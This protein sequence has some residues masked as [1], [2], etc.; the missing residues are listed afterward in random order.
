[1]QHHRHTDFGMGPGFPVRDFQI[2]AYHTSRWRRHAYA[3]EELR[4][5]EGVFP[6]RI[7]AGQ[8]E[9][10]GCGNAA[11]PSR[12]SDLERRIQCHQ[13]RSQIRGMDDKARTATK[14]RVLL[15][16]AI[17]REALVASCLETV[18]TIAV[19]PAPGA[20]RDIPGQR[21]HV[22]YLRCPHTGGGLTQH[23]PWS[24]Q[25]GMA[26]KLGQGDESADQGFRGG[27]RHRTGIAYGAQI[28]NDVGLVGP[29]FDLLQQIRPAAG[30]G[31]RPACRCCRTG[32][33]H[34]FGYRTRIDIGQRF[35]PIA[36]SILSR[37][38]GSD[39]MR[40]P[41]ALKMAFATAAGAR[42]MPDS[43]T[44]FA[45]KGPYPSSTSI[46]CTSIWGTSRWVT[47]RAR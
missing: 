41:V 33:C 2:G 36:P 20:L 47:C 40:L 9:K 19:I 1:M 24:G 44:V 31:E 12:T 32:R 29:V 11:L 23:G 13:R 3:G 10:I 43:P 46:K 14:D 35:H 4:G 17:D 27:H 5:N 34:G 38:M 45:P 39:V 37:L 26:G 16:L 30:E 21:G 18:E 42:I 22:A 8:D 7:L 25:R 28:D 15:I 6:R